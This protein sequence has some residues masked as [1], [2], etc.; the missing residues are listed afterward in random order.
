MATLEATRRAAAPSTRSMVSDVGGDSEGL[1]QR[2]LEDLAS[3][4]KERTKAQEGLRQAKAELAD[5]MHLLDSGEDSNML[6]RLQQ[7][8][9][10]LREQERAAELKLAAEKERHAL[11][12][13]KLEQRVVEYPK[14]ENRDILSVEVM[15]L[16]SRV[17]NMTVKTDTP[18]RETKFSQIKNGPQD[19]NVPQAKNGLKCAQALP[20]QERDIKTPKVGVQAEK[21]EPVAQ[22]FRELTTELEA[23]RAAASTFANQQ[24]NDLVLMLRAQA[25]ELRAAEAELQTV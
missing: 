17:K 20:G 25:E 10:E 8:Q 2:A 11:E 6:A 23:M 21:L 18:L 1:R 15:F 22:Q 14:E 12:I 19:V 9:Q 13:L 5:A 24:L 7:A 3:A 4:S 16:R